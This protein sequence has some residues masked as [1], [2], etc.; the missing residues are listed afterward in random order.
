[1]VRTASCYACLASRSRPEV[2]KPATLRQAEGL[3]SVNPKASRGPSRVAGYIHARGPRG[4]ML[5][6]AHLRDCFLELPDPPSRFDGRRGYSQRWEEM[7][8]RDTV[9]QWIAAR[10][11]LPCG[12]STSGPRVSGHRRRR[13][14]S[15]TSL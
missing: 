5:A 7:P 11:G 13:A 4:E 1:M 3:A 8:C 14:V 12:P 9:P 15:I 10:S 2:P 6:T